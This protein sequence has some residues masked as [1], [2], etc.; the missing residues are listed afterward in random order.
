[1]VPG[2]VHRFNQSPAS[3]KAYDIVTLCKAGGEKKRRY[4][5]ENA[6]CIPTEPCRSEVTPHA[7]MISV[8]QMS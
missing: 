4:Q 1:M 2:D 7:H 8:E 6:V 3:S 5:A